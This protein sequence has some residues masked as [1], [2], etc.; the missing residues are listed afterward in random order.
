MSEHVLTLAAARCA[1]STGATRGFRA[2]SRIPLKLSQ[3]AR[4]FKATTLTSS[5]DT[6]VPF[7]PDAGQ[8]GDNTSEG[9]CRPSIR[10]R[11][12]VFKWTLCFCLRK[13]D[14]AVLCLIRLCRI[15]FFHARYQSAQ[16][17]INESRSINVGYCYE[18]SPFTSSLFL[19]VPKET[20][21]LFFPPSLW[22]CSRYLENLKKIERK[23]AAS[24]MNLL[25]IQQCNAFSPFW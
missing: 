19:F 9:F 21:S 10:L 18:V 14:R 12:G 20:F 3:E 7:V 24:F 1:S 2:Y 25:F 17:D 13:H 23:W 16:G 11:R 5:G 15:P 8:S 6:P 22:Q 4:W